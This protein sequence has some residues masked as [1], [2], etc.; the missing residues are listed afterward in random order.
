MFIQDRR[1]VVSPVF[2]CKANVLSWCFYRTS[3][4]VSYIHNKESTEENN[5]LSSNR[6]GNVQGTETLSE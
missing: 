3:K 2:F 1:R 5:E 6:F 4:V